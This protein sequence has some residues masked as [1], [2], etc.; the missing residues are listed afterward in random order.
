MN[1]ERPAPSPDSGSRTPDS[2]FRTPDPGASPSAGPVREQPHLVLATRAQVTAVRSAPSGAPRSR[3][4]AKALAMWLLPGESPAR[5]V[6]VRSP[7]AW[8]WNWPF[9]RLVACCVDQAERV[10]LTAHRRHSRHESYYR[11]AGSP[12]RSD[13]RFC[14]PRLPFRPVWAGTSAA[15]LLPRRGARWPRNQFMGPLVWAANL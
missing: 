7:R 15:L 12:W 9:V 8:W 14:Q 6:H 1:P 3:P 13:C 11:A 5:R 2:G 4:P 10:T